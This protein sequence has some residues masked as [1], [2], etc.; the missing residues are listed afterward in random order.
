MPTKQYSLPSRPHTLIVDGEGN[1]MG[2]I[3]SGNPTVQ[4]NFG[5][6]K[7][8]LGEDDV[9]VFAAQTTTSNGVTGWIPESALLPSTA[10]SQFAKELAMI[11]ADTSALGDAPE[12]DR[13][14]C[15]SAGHVGE[16]SP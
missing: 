7:R 4:L 1:P 15:G 8:I 2:Y 11:V 14:R 3:P 10:R 6:H 5:Q 9:M 12:K 16:R 13:V